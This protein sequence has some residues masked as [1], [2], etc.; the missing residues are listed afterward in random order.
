VSQ[1]CQHALDVSAEI[2]ARTQEWADRWRSGYAEAFKAKPAKE[3][4]GS[5]VAEM[6]N[7]TEALLWK[8]LGVPS[9]FFRG[10]VDPQKLE[11]WRAEQSLPGIRASL[12]TLQQLVGGAEQAGLAGLIVAAHP[13][14][15]RD[16][17]KAIDA[18]VRAADAIPIS[19]FEGLDSHA[20]KI[21]DLY[22]QVQDFK[23]AL[24]ALAQHLDLA[25][26]AEEDGD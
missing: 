2:R 22:E 15:A 12:A 4:L 10:D 16:L 9:G 18:S 13:G 11:A 8:R 26:Q 3:S 5:L 24:V 6:L 25:I 21:E 19:L 1:R 14:E 23:A 20:S 7:V 17:V